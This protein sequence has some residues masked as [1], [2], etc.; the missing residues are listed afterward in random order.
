MRVVL[1]VVI[2]AAVVVAA[3]VVIR[4]LTKPGKGL[5][6]VVEQATVRL[7]TIEQT[8][9]GTGVLECASTATIL[10]KVE[11]KLGEPQ[12]KEGDQ[13]GTDQVLITI[14]ND[15]IV[16]AV[17]LKK[18]EIAKLNEALDELKKPVEERTA[19]KKA[20]AAYDQADTDYQ[21]KK[22]QL[23]D[24][25]AK[26]PASPLS[27]R[28]LEEL[29]Q[30]VELAA[31]SA[32]LAKDA[33]EEAK[34]EV[35]EADV[36]EGEEKVTQA[37]AELDKLQ[38][39]ADGR[40]VR[41]PIAGT[42][43]KVMVKPEAIAVEPD[44]LYPKD[45]PLVI[46]ADLKSV[47]VRGCIYQNDGERL[48]RE[49][50]AAR[51]YKARVH[52]S[53]RDRVLDGVLTYLSRTLVESSSGAN[54]FEVKIEFATPPEEVTAGLQVAFDITVERVEHVLVVPVRFVELRGSKAYVRKAGAAEP[55]EVRLGASDNNFYQV[56]GGLNEGDV[57]VWERTAS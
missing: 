52:L 1:R 16:T 6:S 11:G 39:Q 22:R 43:L 13:V 45:T 28:Q 32:E 10:S 51:G 26:G 42:V 49:R 34:K 19:V 38:E 40:Q 15:E 20:K 17:N 46:V 21:R 55:V 27:Q 7:G 57:I 54:Q 56:L 47:L 9:Q 36:Q 41:S 25:E 53:G 18:A 2:A 8:V 33:Y 29:R 35:S 48:D 50:I 24:E 31:R 12:V 14:T 30:D 37:K 4:L 44:K 3:V 5:T 23:E